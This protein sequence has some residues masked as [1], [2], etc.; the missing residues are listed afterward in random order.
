MKGRKKRI[1]RIFT[2][3]VL[4]VVMATFIIGIITFLAVSPAFAGH[5]G[6]WDFGLNLGFPGYAYSSPYHG[7]NGYNNGYGYKGYG[8]GYNRGY[9]YN[10]YGYNGY[11]PYRQHH[12]GWQTIWVR[13]FDWQSGCYV[14]VP[15]K[16]PYGYW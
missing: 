14:L 13:V 5:R 16:V 9:G 3:I 12:R 1:Q 4:G 6:H 15:R 8:Y 2:V 10:E 11:Y 7:Y